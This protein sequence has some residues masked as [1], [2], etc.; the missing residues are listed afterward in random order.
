MTDSQFPGV[1]KTSLYSEHLLMGYR[2]YDANE[3]NPA[4]PFGHGISYTS[5]EYADISVQGRVVNCSITNTGD[6]AGKEIVQLYIGFPEEA[7][8]PPKLLKGFDKLSL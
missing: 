3:V 7:G 5:Y 6:V 8:E 1:N 2:W 4:Y